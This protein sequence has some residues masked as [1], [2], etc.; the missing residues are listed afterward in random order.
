MG[1]M[2][3]QTH[4]PHGSGDSLQDDQVNLILGPLSDLIERAR[5]EIIGEIQDLKEDVGIIAAQIKREIKD[6]ES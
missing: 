1:V 3:K 4:T 2:T 6:Y 5:L